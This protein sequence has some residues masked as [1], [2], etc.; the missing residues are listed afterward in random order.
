MKRLLP[1]TVLSFLFSVQVIAQKKEFEKELYIGAG[2][3]AL[4][5]SVDFKPNV[6]QG[7]L[8][9]VHGGIS[10]RYISEKNIG[11]LQ[12]E[13]NYAQSGWVEKF[14]PETNFAYN[15]TLHYL[16]IPLLWHIYGGDKI[17]FIFNAGPQLGFLLGSSDSMNEA[18]A[19]DIA[20]KKQQ[21][22][23]KEKEIGM[24]YNLKPRKID[25]GI[26][27]GIGMEFKTGAGNISLEGRYY[28]G[29][30]DIFENR[31][32]KENFLFDRSANRIIEVKL[33]YFF[34]KLF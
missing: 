22:P 18:L 19:A 17:R 4:M 32:T 23:E 34:K 26:I 11:G 15:R 21:N 9:G 2:G 6:E 30:G 33:S 10:A 31:R 13:I 1:I 16:Q 8:W 7:Q 12:L 25:Y 20:A 29:L 28:F 27:G 5:S 24:R 3:G 14:S